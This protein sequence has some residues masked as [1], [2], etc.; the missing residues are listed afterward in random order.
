MTTMTTMNAN[1]TTD[2]VVTFEGAWAAAS[3]S[4]ARKW[5]LYQF[6]P[7]ASLY[8]TVSERRGLMDVS[9]P[10]KKSD[11][12]GAEFTMCRGTIRTRVCGFAYCT[13]DSESAGNWY[14]EECRRYGYGDEA[15]ASGSE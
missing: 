13:E 1:T 3:T 8:L 7:T 2:A 11:A 10:I 4:E 14:C 12:A 5:V 9:V 6:F 15:C